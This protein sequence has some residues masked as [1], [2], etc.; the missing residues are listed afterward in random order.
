MNVQ[1]PNTEL[2]MLNWC[3]LALKNAQKQEEIATMLAEFGYDKAVIEVG[4]RLCSEANNAYDTNRA[5]TNEQGAA[6]ARFDQ[7][8]QTLK[9][10]YSLFRKKAKVVFRKTPLTLSQLAITG[11]IPTVYVNWI[12]GVRK[13]CKVALADQEIINALQPLRVTAEDLNATLALCDEVDSLRA[14]YLIEKGESQNATKVKDAAFMALDDWM[15][16]FY[17][18]AKIALDEKPQLLEA[19]GVLVRS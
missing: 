7:K 2:A 10:E 14:A 5:E 9:K 15:R 4:K 8:R 13:F 19:L 1:K 3:D 6:Y 16:D 18:V 17:A 11:E 12:E